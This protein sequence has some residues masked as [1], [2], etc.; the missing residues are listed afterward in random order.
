MIGVAMAFM[1]GV[2]GHGSGRDPHV[3]LSDGY[4][5]A[6]LERGCGR[7]ATFRELVGQIEASDLIVYVRSSSAERPGP[8][9]RT[10]FLTAAAGRRYV[11]ISLSRCLST[12]QLVALLGHELQHALE[13]GAAPEVVDEATLRRL[14]ERIGTGGRRLDGTWQFDTNAAVVT[15]R[16]VLKEISRRGVTQ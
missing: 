3:R 16:R 4:S 11:V 13:I 8:I 5:R 2:C 6:L 10:V 12:G 7:S 9:G 15:G 1:L 14:Y